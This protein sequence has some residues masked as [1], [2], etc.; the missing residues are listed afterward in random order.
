MGIRKLCEKCVSELSVFCVMLTDIR[1]LYSIFTI[2]LFMQTYLYRLLFQV[3]RLD[4]AHPELLTDIELPAR[5]DDRIHKVS[6]L[7]FLV[8]DQ[9]SCV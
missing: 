2:M 1:S 9:I 6:V 5:P 3:I 4:L 8:D 7:L